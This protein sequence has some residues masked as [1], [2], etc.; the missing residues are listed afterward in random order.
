MDKGIQI[1]S[2]IAQGIEGAQQAADTGSYHQ[3]YRNVALF[4]VLQDAHRGRA[5][6]TAAGKDQA[7][8]GTVLSDL[9]HP[10]TDFPDG[11]GITG[12]QAEGREFFLLGQGRK[13]Q[14]Q[15]Q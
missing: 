2:I 13:R 8:R 11:F 4:Q 14:Q 3:V 15:Q 5:L 6:G 7:H 9:G 1:R 10:V 12:F